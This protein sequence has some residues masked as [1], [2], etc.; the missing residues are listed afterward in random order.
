MCERL[1]GY[2]HQCVVSFI[3]IY[4]KTMRN[5]PGVTSVPRQ[6]QEHITRA[7]VPIAEKYGIRIYMCAEDP[8]LARFG[9]DVS[10]CMTQAVIERAIGNTLS[11]PGS[12]NRARETCDCLLGSDIGVY[13]TCA[14]GCLYCYANYSS[15]AVRRN[16]ADHDPA[17]PFLI[18]HLR[19]EDVV[20]DAVQVSYIDGQ[21]RLPI[22]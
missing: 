17:S 3:D 15:E 19:P 20:K 6:E 8:S 5:F 9:A 12:K 11:V 2:T 14:H 21:M 16:M 1:C 10:G 7:F 22:W 18:G 13:N 4:E